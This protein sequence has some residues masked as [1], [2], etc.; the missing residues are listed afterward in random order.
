MS[1][2]ESSGG[3]RMRLAKRACMSD[4]ISESCVSLIVARKKSSPL[5]LQSVELHR[6][7]QKQMFELRHAGTEK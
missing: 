1:A 5:A 3:P 2:E 6:S 4:W 7:E